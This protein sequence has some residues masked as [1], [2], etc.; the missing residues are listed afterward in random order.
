MQKERDFLFLFFSKHAGLD[1]HL[2]YG[3]ISSGSCYCT[4]VFEAGAGDG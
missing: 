2:V 4:G 3:A 1:F